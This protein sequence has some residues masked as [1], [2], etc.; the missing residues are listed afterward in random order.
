MSEALEMLFD[1][2][3]WTERKVQPVDWVDNCRHM[4]RRYY[5]TGEWKGKENKFIGQLTWHAGWNPLRRTRLLL[6][7]YSCGKFIS[8]HMLFS[9]QYDA[10]ADGIHAER[11]FMIWPPAALAGKDGVR[12]AGAQIPTH[13]KCHGDAGKVLSNPSSTTT[14]EYSWW[15]WKEI[16]SRTIT[17]INQQSEERTL[18]TWIAA[19]LNIPTS[20]A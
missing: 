8:I 2:F 4:C 7:R 13:P 19:Q 18:A 16:R 20:S 9:V 11:A 3:R 17:V 15:I 1:G 14:G 10:S 12:R 5:L 6:D